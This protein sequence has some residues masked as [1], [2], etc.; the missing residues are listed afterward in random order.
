[1]KQDSLQYY[2]EAAVR[3]S[4]TTKDID[5]QETQNR[6]LKYLASGARIL[7][8]GCGSGRDTSIFLVRDT[9]LKLLTDR[10]NW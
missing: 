8:F 3:F 5:F 6:F 4:E 2:N 10:K 9:R 1:M 7:D